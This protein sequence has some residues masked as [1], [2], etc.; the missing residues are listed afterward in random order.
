MT[1]LTEQNLRPQGKDY[2]EIRF[3]TERQVSR[4]LNHHEPQ[5]LTP[6]RVDQQA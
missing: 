6:A 1:G 3:H 5:T 2:L 4:V